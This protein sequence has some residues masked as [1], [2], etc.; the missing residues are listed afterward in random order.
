M[1]ELVLGQE[2]VVDGRGVVGG[3]QGQAGM[4]SLHESLP[5]GGESDLS[6]E[7]AE[8]IMIIEA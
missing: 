7:A 2:D 5:V 8:M 4:K 6:S 3:F 1:K